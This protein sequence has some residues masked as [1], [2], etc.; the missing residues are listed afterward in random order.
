MLAR[1]A[2]VTRETAETAVRLDLNLDGTGSC[3]A[4]TG[5][6]FFEH[7]L[8]LFTRFAAFDVEVVA[9]GDLNVDA[10]HTVEDVGIA[11]GQAFSRAIGTKEGIRRF[12][13]AV[14]PMDEALA[15]A[16][17][18][19]S[20]RGHFVFNGDLPA[21][22]VGDFDTELVPEFFRALAVNAG[23]T[24]HLHVLSGRN[25]HHICEA[26]FKACGRAMGDAVA[27]DPRGKG[28]PSTKGTL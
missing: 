5:V 23:I 16:A 2:V 24:L 8:R 21:P 9:E 4:K 1:K 13:H 25:T 22:R 17:V 28:I 27:F 26:L 10:H 12:G 15:L 18:D 11:I 20:G 7:M 3:S 19:I 14:V 6:G